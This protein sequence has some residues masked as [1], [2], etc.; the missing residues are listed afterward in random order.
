M[1]NKPLISVL[2]PAYNAEKTIERCLVSLSQQTYP[3]FEI[4]LI[5]DGST[6]QTLNNALKLA[7]VDHRLKVFDQANKGVSPSRN[8]AID[9]AQG[10]FFCCVDADDYVE[11]KYLEN[12]LNGV[13]FEIGTKGLV[14]Q[15]LRFLEQ[16][17]QLLQANCAE[18]IDKI[19]MN[20]NYMSLFDKFDIIRYGF[21]CGKLFSLDVVRNNKIKYNESISISEDLIFMLEYIYNSDY[22]H[23]IEGSDYN[24]IVTP[25]ALQT[26][27]F[28]SFSSERELLRKY[29]ILLN[30]IKVKFNIPDQ[31]LN[32]AYNNS[33]DILMRLVYSMYRLNNPLPERKARV[34]NIKN[35]TE[36]FNF[37]LKRHFNKTEVK[38]KITKFLLVNKLYILFDIYR[39]LIRYSQKR[40][41]K[42]L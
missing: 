5:N 3:N 36:E 14:I 29:Q 1:T 33:G 20:N 30:D 9:L 17:E 37:C 35:V 38:E 27:K 39:I 10:T 23:F 16:S 31:I 6:D 40:K 11:P 13:V 26:V 7:N 2:I 15:Q 19:I 42:A 24:Y 12:L 41:M 18:F 4:I 21:N 28:A 22:V 25:Y 32:L 34:N 8:R